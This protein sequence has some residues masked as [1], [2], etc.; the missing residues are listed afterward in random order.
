MIGGIVTETI[1]LP[2]K[3]WV[4][5]VERHEACN[6][7]RCLYVEHNPDSARIKPGDS[8][9]WQG[10]VALWTRY[11]TKGGKCGVD[12]DIQIPRIGFSGVARPKKSATNSIP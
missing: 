2:E 4:E 1:I 3:V 9:W 6:D 11:G 12:Y 10:K 8:L 7:K 5:V